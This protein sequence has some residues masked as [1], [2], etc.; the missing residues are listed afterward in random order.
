MADPQEATAQIPP[1][2]PPIPSGA[3]DTFGLAPRDLPA[4]QDLPVKQ[5]SLQS[6]PQPVEPR[7]A[8]GVDWGHVQPELKSR[9]DAALV[10]VP[11]SLRG[12]ITITSGFRT[13]EQQ[14]AAWNRFQ[15]GQGGLAARPGMSRHEHG[16]AADFV[17]KSPEADRAFREAAAKQGIV[18]PFVA[19]GDAGHMQL[20]GGPKA[21]N[22][23]GSLTLYGHSSAW[24]EPVQNLMRERTAAANA[25]AA[26]LRTKMEEYQQAALKAAPGSKERDNAI[27]E[28]HATSTRLMKRMEDIAAHPPAEKPV[29]AFEGFGSAATIFG[30][31]GG[32]FAR[33]HLTAALGAAGMAMKAIK[34]NNREKFETDFKLWKE[35]STVAMDLVKLQN[36][37][38]RGLIED[39]KLSV[40]EKQTQL[41]NLVA[42]FKMA[43]SIGGLATSNLDGQVKLYESLAGLQM[44]MQNHKDMMQL[45]YDQ[46]FLRPVGASQGRERDLEAAIAADVAKVRAANPNATES[47][48]SAARYESRLKHEKEMGAATRQPRSAPAM[49]LQQFIE[50]Y[51]AE[52]DGKPPS[53]TE[54]QNFAAQ[55]AEKNSEGRSVGTRAATLEIAANTADALI[56]LLKT[57]SDKIN[58]TEYPKINSLILAWEKGTGDPLV[59]QYGEQLNTLLYVYARTLNPSGQARQ[60][61][62]ARLQEILDAAW[63]KGQINA[64]LDQMQTTIAA[65][66]QAVQ[67]TRQ[68]VRSG[69]IDNPTPAA[70]TSGGKPKYS[71]DQIIEHGGRKYRVTG[72]D[73]TKDP[74][75]ELVQ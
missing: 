43:E 58:R 41:G 40:D 12:H 6:S 1:A 38:W 29:D 35:Q 45:H 2:P 53:S 30:M 33:R 39:K 60:G 61:D 7:L 18:F 36:E 56:P 64:A 32:L 21:T 50:E 37:Q 26:D 31:I 74:D 20:Q 66:K 67:K 75:V 72:G 16:L 55:G 23:D 69:T 46:L 11:E 3:A 15:S 68:E 4:R 57:A 34:D 54:I 49:A 73:L 65:E 62:L 52:H 25:E 9:I 8:P 22:P 27:A 24:A 51:A 19:Q 44:Q 28:S 47:E 17:S 63:S 59:V 42:Q 14:E 48:L 70:K 5:A 10:E 71:V 13:H